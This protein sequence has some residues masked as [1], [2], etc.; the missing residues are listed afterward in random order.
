MYQI[1]CGNSILFDPRDDALMVLNPKCKLEVNT[2]GEASFTILPNHPNIDKL[3]KLR[4]VFEIWQG[5]DVIFRGRMTNDTTD[6]HNRLDVDLEGALAYAND[7]IIPPF[8]F[9]NDDQFAGAANSGNVV[10]YLLQWVIDRHNEQASD[11]QKFQLG[12]VTVTDPNNNIERASEGYSTTWDILREKF[13]ESSLGGYLFV[14]YGANGVNYIDYLASFPQTHS[15]QI[16]FGE[17]LMDI[18]RQTN[19]DATYTAMLPTGAES[20]HTESAGDDYQGE[21][22]TIENT[23]TVKD[24]L[25]LESL[26]DG[27]LSADGDIV[28]KGKFIYSKSGVSKY[29]WICMPIE[30]SKFEDVTEVENLKTKSVAALKS[31]TSMEETIRVQ[32]LD[33]HFTDAQIAA[34]RICVNVRVA[35]APHNIN[36]TYPLE[37]LEID[38]LNP[39]NT[40]FT[41]GATERVLTSRANST[42]KSVSNIASNYPTSVELFEKVNRL[43][44]AI[45][46]AKVTADEACQKVT[47]SASSSY[48]SKDALDSLG[49]KVDGYDD[50]LNDHARRIYFAEGKIEVMPGQILSTVSEG[51]ATKDGLDG[52]N[53]RLVTAESSISQQADQIASRVTQTDFDALGERVSGAESSIIQMPTEIMAA[54]AAT[55][56]TN[57]DLEEAESRITQRA[58][59]ISLSVEG[60]ER[61]TSE[62]QEKIDYANAELMLKIDKNDNDQIISMINA[63]ADDI[64]IESDTMTIKNS[65]FELKNGHVSITDG[66]LVCAVKGGGYVAINENWDSLRVAGSDNSKLLSLSDRGIAIQNSNFGFMAITFY[67]DEAAEGGYGGNLYGTWYIHNTGSATPVTSD[68]TKKNNIQAQADVYSRI[69]D[70]LKPV[71]FKYNNGTSDRVHT[72]L[73]AQDVEQAVIAEGL[74][75]QE[76]AALC[77]DTDESGNKKNYGVRYEELV[78]MCIKE[79][80]GLKARI[81]ELEEGK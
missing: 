34:F 32:G 74:T 2:C 22:V 12:T 70:R 39:Q 69:F 57:A 15:Q 3:T 18:E 41:I 75:T 21:Y 77:Y 44:N 58:D 14:R 60:L 65:G 80:Q 48:A 51:Y 66:D 11:F 29:G 8:N 28:K 40:I 1:K 68:E 55:Y 4:S 37:R 42:A 19:A 7:T 78:S 81:A 56:A 71:T 64:N 9:P 73:I 20:E 45:F 27:A 67:D 38:L 59:E 17:N 46:E 52:V 31:K 47:I 76:F 24:V 5:A 13:F 36:G 54:V 33:L 62:T 43:E 53:D 25:T 50:T 72:G 10:E 49:D 35:S 26:P 16:V 30:E 6:F 63:S 61:Y 23:K 79:I